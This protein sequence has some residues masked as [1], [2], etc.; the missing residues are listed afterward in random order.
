MS[1][2]IIYLIIGKKWAVGKLYF[3]DTILKS[4]YWLYYKRFYGLDNHGFGAFPS[5]STLCGLSCLGFLDFCGFSHFA[6]LPFMK[7][8]DQ[9]EISC[10]SF[11]D[12]VLLH[13]LFALLYGIFIT[14]PYSAWCRESVSTTHVRIRIICVLILLWK[15]CFIKTFQV[16]RQVFSVI[17]KIITSSLLCFPFGFSVPMT[18][19]FLR[20]SL[21]IS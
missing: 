20:H 6:F 11:R 13:F 18:C 3:W 15:A 9:Y 5:F 17:Y 21:Q 10:S 19:V 16:C 7:C 8:R 14:R 4:F 12:F 2:L 1:I